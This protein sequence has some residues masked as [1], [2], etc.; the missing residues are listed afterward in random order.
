MSYVHGYSEREAQRLQDQA[1]A[2]VDLLHRGVAFPPGSRVLE[3]GCGVGAQ[4]VTLTAR[5]PGALFTAVDRDETSLAA[6][7]RAVAAAGHGN[8]AFLQA[9]LRALPFADAA[10]DHAFACFVLEHVPSPPAL[11]RELARVVRP[12][13]TLTVIEG[14][15]GSAF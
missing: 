15:H 4:T 10:F 2:L 1:G 8:V 9:D 5:S 11:L 13:G 3:A 14:D 12:G 6:A 7:R